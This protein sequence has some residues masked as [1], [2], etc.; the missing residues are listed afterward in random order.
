MTNYPIDSALN[1]EE[2]TIVIDLLNSVA[3]T[4]FPEVPVF[5]SNTLGQ[6]VKEYHA[7]LGIIPDAK[8]QFKNKRTGRDTKDTNET[9]EGL[10]L[11]EGDV[12]AICDDGNV[13]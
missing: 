9:V 11:E 10:G 4:L 8:L 6:I 13:A 2:N 7:K 12:L 5:K 3:G 1:T